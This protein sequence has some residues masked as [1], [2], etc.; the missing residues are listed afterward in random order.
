MFTPTRDDLRPR[1]SIS[2]GVSLWYIAQRA[3]ISDKSENYVLNHV[4]LLHLNEGFPAP[5]PTFRIATGKRVDGIV[6]A[7]RWPRETVDAWFDGFLPPL[8]ST[9]DDEGAIAASYAAALDGAAA[10][11]FGGANPVLSN[12]EGSQP[13]AELAGVAA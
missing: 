10:S 5:L 1:G 12:V 6:A 8:V 13:A 11:L 7:S 2:R 9:V 3:G 4:R